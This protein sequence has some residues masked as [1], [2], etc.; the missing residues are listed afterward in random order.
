MALMADDPPNPR[1][2]GWYPTRP[3]SPFWGAVL[4][5]QLCSFFLGINA[6][7]AIGARCSMVFASPPAS[8]SPTVIFGFSLR[9]DASAAPA[10][11]PPTIT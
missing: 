9:R 1:P 3:L 6:T 5:A 11:P 4:N 8:N 10:D 2:R 7:T